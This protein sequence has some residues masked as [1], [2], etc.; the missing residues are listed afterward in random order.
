MTGL[1]SGSVPR[2]N[3]SLPAGVAS[4]WSGSVEN[5]LVMET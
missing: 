1:D 4:E 5:Y 3:F 2:N